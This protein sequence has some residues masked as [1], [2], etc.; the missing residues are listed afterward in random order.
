V[1][2]KRKYLMNSI[3]EHGIYGLIDLWQQGWPTLKASPD[4]FLEKGIIP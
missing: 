1:P 3:I 2:F 4:E